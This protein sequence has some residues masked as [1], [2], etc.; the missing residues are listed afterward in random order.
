MPAKKTEV[1]VTGGKASLLAK[2]GEK[3]SMDPKVFLDTV[4]KTVFRDAKNMEQVVTL[5]MVADQY[6]LNPIT[7]EIM[8]FPDKAGGVTPVVGVYSA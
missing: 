1:A 4:Q 5:L 7:R 2:F 8:A 6:G 3:Y